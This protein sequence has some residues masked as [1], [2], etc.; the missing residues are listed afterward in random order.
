MLRKSTE[1]D[2][3]RN[4]HW[5]KASVALLLPRP[6]GRRFGD[7]SLSFKSLAIIHGTVYFNM[8]TFNDCAEN[9]S[10]SLLRSAYALHYMRLKRV[11]GHKQHLWIG[12]ANKNLHQASSVG[13]TMISERNSSPTRPVWFGFY[14]KFEFSIKIFQFVPLKI[15][16]WIWWF[17]N[18]LL[19]C[20]NTW[21]K[22]SLFS[23]LSSHFK[24]QHHHRVFFSLL[25]LLIH[26][27]LVLEN[28]S[29]I[30]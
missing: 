6:G 29:V 5:L 26:K 24:D 2:W 10:I 30:N 17:V 11:G 18:V 7:E 28:T 9:V 15:K 20:F 27:R 22:R 25:R 16:K 21:K 19:M 14:D 4:N 23:C 12:Q 13:E 3:L 1:K 8:E